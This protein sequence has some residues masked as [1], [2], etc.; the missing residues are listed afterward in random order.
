[1]NLNA[2]F[3]FFYVDELIRQHWVSWVEGSL[4]TKP[5]KSKHHP[6]GFQETLGDLGAGPR[7]RAGEAYNLG[8]LSD[9]IVKSQR[10]GSGFPAGWQTVINGGMP[11]TRLG[12]Y[13]YIIGCSLKN[14]PSSTKL[15]DAVDILASI[16][17]LHIG[18][19]LDGRW[20]CTV[21]LFNFAREQLENTLG[22]SLA[23]KEMRYL[24]AAV[25]N[26]LESDRS[27]LILEPYCN[28]GLIDKLL[29]EFNDG[30]RKVF[31]FDHLPTFTTSSAIG[32]NDFKKTK[33]AL[34]WAQEKRGIFTCA[35]RSIG[36]NFISELTDI[37]RLLANN[38]EQNLVGKTLENISL[39]KHNS[40]IFEFAESGFS[41]HPALHTRWCEVET[42]LFAATN[43]AAET[44]S[45]DK[46]H[47]Q[48]KV[49]QKI[50][51]SE[52]P[53]ATSK[54]SEPVENPSKLYKSKVHE[55]K[56]NQKAVQEDIPRS[57][58]ISIDGRGAMQASNDRQEENIIKVDQLLS[59]HFNSCVVN[60][61]VSK[62]NKSEKTSALHVSKPKVTKTDFAARDARNRALGEAGEEFIYLYERQRLIQAD[63][64]D[65]AEKVTWASRDI[66]D[67]LGY[68]IIS[69]EP[70]G[71]EI[72]LEVKTTTGGEG[73]PFYVSN[74]EVVVSAEKSS[75]YK[76]VR[77][78]KFPVQPKFFV[79]SGDLKTSLNLVA[80]SYR[81]SL[82]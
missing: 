81:A 29:F 5:D 54:H 72:Y 65:L 11:A 50:I 37:D 26:T 28:L 69:F 19:K 25:I 61:P 64:A 68:D 17:I 63:R 15:Q 24:T 9:R 77:L 7:T 46:A 35:S 3:L 58:A 14:N 16:L 10:K 52:E 48:F 23:P 44:V 80:S 18:F 71:E 1:M 55:T 32:I 6:R 27:S 30:S 49:A 76:L 66:G 34:F 57:Q 2:Q 39:G 42:A 56:L 20:Y 70:S 60:V 22:R 4:S 53:T 62:S 73:T 51:R 79:L 8:I 74:N 82:Q 78:Y 59:S 38:N 13:S 47:D 12:F 31:D 41:D 43:L 33:A 40:G 36:I 21:L 75:A 67:G 45:S